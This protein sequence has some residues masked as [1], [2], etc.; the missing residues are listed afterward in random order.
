MSK[1]LTI[2]KIRNP[3]TITAKVTEVT[4]MEARNAVIEY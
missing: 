1:R 3:T 2:P 4:L